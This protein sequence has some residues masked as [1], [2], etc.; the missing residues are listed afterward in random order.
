MTWQQISDLQAD[1]NEIGG[2]TV[3]H[4]DLT[5]TTLSAAEKRRQVCEDRQNLVTRGFNPVSFAYP[6]S[7]HDAAARTIVAEC[8]YSSARGAG[9]APVGGETIPPL[10]PFGTRTPD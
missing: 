4:V 6:Y 8:G 7:R 2:H 5:S 3:D 1:G 9:G 10:D